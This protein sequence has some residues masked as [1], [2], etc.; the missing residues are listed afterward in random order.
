MDDEEEIRKL[1]ALEAELAR[2][3]SYISDQRRN[4][5]DAKDSNVRSKAFV[6]KVISLYSSKW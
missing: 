1:E 5:V 2:E 4:L 6:S 3:A